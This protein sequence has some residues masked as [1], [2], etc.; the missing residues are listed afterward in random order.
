MTPKDARAIR[1]AALMHDVGKLAVHNAVLQ[2]DGK[3]TDHEHA[4]MRRHPEHG[5]ELAS[6]IELLHPVLD[7]IRHHHERWDGAGYPDG[8]VG[9]DIPIAARIITVSDAFDAMTSTRAYRPARSIDAAFAELDRCAGS[10]F[11]PAAV[12]ALKRAVATGRWSPAPE[13]RAIEI[14]A[15]EPLP[16]VSI[17]LG[18]VEHARR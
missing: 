9:E 10:Q 11:D 17:R 18:S 1:Y 7:G 16:Q 6:G 2:K 8:L 3:L 5:V 4:H 12:A 15:A 13:P 14:A